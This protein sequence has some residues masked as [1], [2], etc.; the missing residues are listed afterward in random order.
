MYT[1]WPFS[2]HKASLENGSE[3]YGSQSLTLKTCTHLW[4]MTHTQPPY[5]NKSLDPTDYPSS[6][7]SHNSFLWS[8]FLSSLFGLQ[9][10]DFRRTSW[11]Q[12]PVALSQTLLCHY[13]IL[14]PIALDTAMLTVSLN[15][16]FSAYPNNICSSRPTQI[17]PLMKYSMT[18]LALPISSFSMLFCILRQC[19]ILLST[20]VPAVNS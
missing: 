5:L 1:S 14:L 20:Y 12:M 9:Q 18:S 8:Q 2:K 17:F 19:S 3:I 13:T 10:Q 11:L 4:R 15:V 7:I 6:L 16:A